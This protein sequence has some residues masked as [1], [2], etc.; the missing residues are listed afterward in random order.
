MFQQ[1]MRMYIFLLGRKMK[2]MQ[3]DQGYRKKP[4]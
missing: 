4:R 1:Q 3:E 2:I